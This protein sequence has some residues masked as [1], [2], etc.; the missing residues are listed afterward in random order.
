MAQIQSFT[1]RRVEGKVAGIVLPVP[2]A[3]VALKVAV[4]IWNRIC[5]HGSQL[6]PLNH[7]LPRLSAQSRVRCKVIHTH[8]LVGAAGN[9]PAGRSGSQAVSRGEVV[10]VAN[11]RVLSGPT[12][13]CRCRCRHVLSFSTLPT[14]GWSL[15]LRGTSSCAHSTVDPG[16]QPDLARRADQGITASRHRGLRHA[17][18]TLATHGGG[19]GAPNQQE[20]KPCLAFLG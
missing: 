17:H 19:G 12:S 13:R 6:D 4:V 14:N 5:V 2:R 7:Q 1:Q 15:D 16:P 10:S 11:L 3:R 8:A 9:Q 18:T 20:N